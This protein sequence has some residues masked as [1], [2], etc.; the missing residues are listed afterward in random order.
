[1]ARYKINPGQFKHMIIIERHQKIKDEDNRF[2]EQWIRLCSARAKI[3]IGK[4]AG[5]FDE[6]NDEL[7][8]LAEEYN[9]LVVLCPVNNAIDQYCQQLENQIE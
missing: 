1:M 4:R 8:Q 3:F 5:F 9:D 6:Y 2:V 7:K